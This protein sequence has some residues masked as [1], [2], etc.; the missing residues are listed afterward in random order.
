MTNHDFDALNA[1]IAHL[2]AALPEADLA[3]MDEGYLEAVARHALTIRAS[4]PWGASL[5]EDIFRIYTLFP[6]VNNERL[7]FYH[8]AIAALLMPRLVGLSMGEA[9]LAVN[10]WCF[11]QATYRSTSARTASPLT[12]MRA[13]S[14][15]CGEE[16]T[17]A[18]SAM[19]SVGLPAR[20][21]YVPRWAH[22][23]DNHAWI[24]V[25]IDGAWRYMGAC[26]PEMV[27]D[28]GWFTSA[29]SRAM[30]VHTRAY[31]M[32]LVGERVEAVNGR[33]FTINRTAAY[34]PTALVRVRV[35]DRGAPRSDVRVLFE[36]CNMA[37]FFSICEKLTGPDGCADLLTGLGSLRVRALD[38]EKSVWTVLDARQS[39]ECALD[40]KDA[41]ALEPGPRHFRLIPPAETRIQPAPAP[42]P[43]LTAHLDKLRRAARLRE[44]RLAGWKTGN[45]YAD[46]AGGNAPEI[47][48][49]LADERY[50]EAEKKLLL[51]SLS[52]KDFYD[53]DRATLSDALENALPWKGDFEESVW[54]KYL[55]CPRVA[56]EELWPV[57]RALKGALPALKTPQEIWAFASNAVQVRK[58][59]PPAVFPDSLMALSR[60]FT[61][62]PGLDVLF[63]AACRASGIPARLNPATGEKEYF[64]NGN[65]VPLLADA[66]AA[67][68]SLTLTT[69]AELP[70]F[71]RFTLSRAKGG[72]DWTLDYEGMA[73]KG[74]KTLQL[75]P[76]NYR[77]TVVTRQIDG[78]VDGTILPLTLGE[79][80]ALKIHVTP[81]PDGTR[82]KLLCATLPP[83]SAS[84]PDRK[85]RA[86]PM[87]GSR[88]LVAFLAPGEEPTEHFLVELTER[89]AEFVRRGVAVHLIVDEPANASHPRLR[90]LLDGFPGA[91]VLVSRDAAALLDWHRALH[92]GDLRR[93]FAAA[94]DGEGKGL[95]A[96][97][98]YFVGSVRALINILDCAPN[99][100]EKR[101]EN[102]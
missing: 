90:A 99:Q 38:G 76:G 60:G 41:V 55:L 36:L 44:E 82:E 56:N 93:P 61:N 23:D 29:A 102:P 63:V 20:Q 8:E 59:A 91:E 75:R 17:L 96:F 46:R 30:L 65:F 95:F 19:R 31:G 40:L 26:E 4:V 74:R 7:T 79:G 85:P 57:R 51:D 67:G 92:C 35:T 12:V 69:D 70:Y 48:A 94:I 2:K 10:H 34:A 53:V 45:P 89:K 54:Q 62:A 73:L 98:N 83:L 39:Q 14:A 16:S 22:C 37:E 32:P 15:R 21:C 1:A 66:A 18:V 72:R 77:L 25:W 78:T 28:S 50:P 24:E 42:G 81:P 43:A 88:A 3:Q 33:E 49:F 84:A 47:L 9:A 97:S 80:E 100:H 101:E 5:P 58:L 64:E 13:G 52:E 86:L 68:A 6:R 87:P 27:L 71:E 11:E